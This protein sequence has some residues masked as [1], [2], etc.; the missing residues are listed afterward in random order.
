[1]RILYV[2][3]TFVPSHFGGVK[4]VSYQLSK[5]MVQRGHDVVV[6]TTDADSD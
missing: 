1:M 6:F 4:E 5:N 3:P 2:T